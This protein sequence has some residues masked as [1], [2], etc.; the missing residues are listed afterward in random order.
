MFSRE[1]IIT[2]CYIILKEFLACWDLELL[3]PFPIKQATIQLS[4]A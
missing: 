1:N 4:F 3:S 2:F